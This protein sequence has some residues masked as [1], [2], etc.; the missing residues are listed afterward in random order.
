MSVFS[1]Q[2][3][4]VTSQSKIPDNLQVPLQQGMVLNTFASGVQIYVCKASDANNQYKW[5]FKAPEAVLL[6]SKTGK[7]LGKHYAGPTWEALDG[8][9]VVGKVENMASAIDVKNIPWLLLTAKSHINNGVFSNINYIQR[10]D[11]VGGQA[12]TT[13]CDSYNVGKEVRVNY[14]ANYYFFGAVK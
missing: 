13:G 10:V 14:T 12:P 9:K 1:F 2:S 11:T 6:D 3:S 4:I 8:S 7:K 5:T